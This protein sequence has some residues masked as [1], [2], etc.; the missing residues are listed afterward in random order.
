MRG[1]ARGI[2]FIRPRTPAEAVAEY[3]R[4]PEALPLAGGTDL[5]VAWNAGLLNGRSVLDLSGLSEWRAIRREEGL[6]RL[7]AL[8][9]HSDV[10]LHPEVRRRF[11]LL[12]QACSMV[13][14]VQIQNRGTLGGNIANAS[15][16]GDT[17]PALAVYEAK[18]RL[19]SPSGRKAVPV[20]G[21]LAGVKRTRLAPSELIEA[22][23]LPVPA[24][25]P[26]RSLWR[27]V[28]PRS[29]Q[30]ISKLMA[31]GLLWLE[32]DGRVR[33]LRFAL[34]SMAPTTRRLSAAEAFVAGKKP[35]RDVVREAC[36]LLC[37]D[38]SPIDDFRSTAEY[39][40]RVAQN[41]LADFLA[42]GS[43]PELP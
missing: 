20:L 3:G 23:E 32:R 38:V 21:L 4:S 17:L 8:A 19:V 31:A 29:A 16:A 11:P 34:G 5:M 27:K 41:L 18:V 30:A 15:P 36:R 39:R 40:L 6:L 33:E 35:S 24:P 10:R 25:R 2:R 37:K 28:G 42:P 13:G 12:A 26:A 9:T 43:R 1:D 22:V 14:S 7:G